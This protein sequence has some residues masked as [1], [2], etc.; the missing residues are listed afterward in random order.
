MPPKCLEIIV[1]LCFEKRFAKQNSVIR[2]NQTFCSPKFLGWLRH[3]IGVFK[4][5]KTIG[6]GTRLV[7]FE[8]ETKPETNKTETYKNGSR[9]RDQV[10][11][12]QHFFF[13]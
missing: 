7:A 3:C 2:Q 1:V 10:L 5:S 8:T 9:D 11:R 6:V 13:C 4:V 12:Y